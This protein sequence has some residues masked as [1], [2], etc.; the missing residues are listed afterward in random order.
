MYAVL[1]PGVIALCIFAGPVLSIFGAD[2]A[3]EGTRCLQLLAVSGVFAGF[4]YVADAVL[5]ARKQV[6]RYVF[7]NTAGTVCAI[8][9]PVAFMGYGLTGV[10]VG[11]L[12][13]QIGYSVLAVVT[14]F[15]SRS[16]AVPTTGADPIDVPNPAT[17]A[18]LSTPVPLVSEEERPTP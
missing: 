6:K 1:I 11:W 17:D 18:L 10:G 13:G 9:F 7:L 5:N 8:G 15:A 2:Y 4:N 3:R 12:V 14:L 16:L